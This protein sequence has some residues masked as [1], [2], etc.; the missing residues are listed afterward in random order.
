MS[1]DKTV[2]EA[3]VSDPMSRKVVAVKLMCQVLDGVRSHTT[4]RYNG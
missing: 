1:R 2:N 3:I 4:P